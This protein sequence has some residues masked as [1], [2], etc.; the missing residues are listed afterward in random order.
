MTT[1]NMLA[2]SS[3][4]R[5]ASHRTNSLGKVHSILMRNRK[6]SRDF[7]ALKAQVQFRQMPT[8]VD[9]RMKML[10]K[11]TAIWNPQPRTLSV[12]LGSLLAMTWRILH[13]FWARAQA[14]C[15]VPFEATSTAKWK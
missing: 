10:E 12:N 4:P 6:P 14:G 11:T 2:R 9:Q 15:K 3:G 13:K 1:R 8:L 5:R 7:K